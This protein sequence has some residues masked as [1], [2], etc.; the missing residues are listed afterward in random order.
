VLYTDGVTDAL[1]PE[2]ML[3]EH[4]LMAALA[5]CGGLSA[6]E[7]AQRLEDVA[8]GDDPTHPPRDDMAIVVVKLD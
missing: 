5:D 1:A 7:I 4:D 3:D 2:H 8:L 6:G